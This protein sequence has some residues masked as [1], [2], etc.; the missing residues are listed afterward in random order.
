M[1]VLNI[2]STNLSPGVSARSYRFI[3]DQKD[4]GIKEGVDF[5]A[6][7]LK[8]EVMCGSSR[9]QKRNIRKLKAIQIGFVSL[10]GIA[11]V[12]L[13]S[14]VS[15]QTPGIWSPSIT[16]EGVT[17]TPEVVMEWGLK[18]A[19][20]TVAAGVALAG[21]LLAVAGVYRMLRKRKE[22]EDWTTDIIK[23]LVQVLIAVPIV[24]TLFHL[25]QIVFRN[26]P[27]LDSLM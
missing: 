16:E 14:T 20:M 23:G 5:L 15:A 25:A 9:Q 6:E 2:T 27:V 8:K 18:I 11:A 17:L 13:P 3:A 10:L 22:A 12:M 21:A 24:Y 7:C 1:A 19:L 26:M 4:N